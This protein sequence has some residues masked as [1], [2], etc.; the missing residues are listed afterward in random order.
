[1]GNHT[2]VGKCYHQLYRSFEGSIPGEGPIVDEFFPTV[3]GL[4]F[5]MCM[6]STRIKTHL[7]SNI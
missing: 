5:D 1:M 4:N 3:P 7:P 2:Q 6:I